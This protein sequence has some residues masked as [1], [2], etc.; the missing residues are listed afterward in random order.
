MIDGCVV[1]VAHEFSAEL[2]IGSTVAPHEVF[3]EV[4]LESC[5]VSAEASRDLARLRVDPVEAFVELSDVGVFERDFSRD[6]DERG[7]SAEH[8][9]EHERLH[10][11]PL[12]FEDGVRFDVVSE[13]ELFAVGALRRAREMDVLPHFATCFLYGVVVEG[14]SPF[15][16]RVVSHPVSPAGGTVLDGGSREDPEPAFGLSTGVPS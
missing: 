4:L 7:V 5:A 1:S 9:T 3:G 14:G 16:A 12:L 15:V 11:L 6:L 2:S 10:A 13:K 8:E